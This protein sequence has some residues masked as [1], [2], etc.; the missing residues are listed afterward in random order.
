MSELD[1]LVDVAQ[2]LG[3]AELAEV[4]DL[5]TRLRRHEAESSEADLRARLADPSWRVALHASLQEADASLDRGEGVDG[6][7]FFRDLLDEHPR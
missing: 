4:I 1:R 2:D 6:E 3:P 5:A 7:A